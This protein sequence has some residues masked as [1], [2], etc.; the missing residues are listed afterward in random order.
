[1]CFW[2]CSVRKS[3]MKKQR[4]QKR[5]ICSL[6]PYF[7]QSKPY[8]PQS[9]K[10]GSSNTR[11]LLPQGYWMKFNVGINVKIPRNWFRKQWLNIFG[12]DY[13]KIY[14]NRL[15]FWINSALIVC[16]FS[17]FSGRFL[18]DYIRKNIWGNPHSFRSRHKV[19]LPIKALFFTATSAMTSTVL[20][21]LSA[22]MIDCWLR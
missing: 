20:C 7:P 2:A 3:S 11:S 8:I 10:N 19:I 22:Y 1:M 18:T 21:M 6:P 14:I 13:A 17:F 5:E 9:V 4:I 16:A 12:A 15:T